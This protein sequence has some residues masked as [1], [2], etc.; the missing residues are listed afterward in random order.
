M[1]AKSSLTDSPVGFLGR[2]ARQ[3]EPFAAPVRKPAI[4][5]RLPERRRPRTVSRTR[6]P[7]APLAVA[8]ARVLPA[9]CPVS[10]DG[11]GYR[12]GRWARLSLTL[13]T[14]AA[15]VLLVMSLLPA[16][17]T[18]VRSVTVQ[19]GDTLWSIATDAAGEGDPRGVVDQIRA[20]N[21]LGDGP[22]VEGMQL[23]VPAR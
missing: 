14:V 3:R 13:T 21:G 18:G 20:L 22:L 19:Q 15:A 4:P 9:D 17:S 23:Q 2:S 12:L 6:P 8:P 5:A 16:S 7:I 11:P 10:D 1:S